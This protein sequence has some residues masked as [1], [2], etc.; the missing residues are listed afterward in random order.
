MNLINQQSKT[1]EAANRPT[2]LKR[3]QS[4]VVLALSLFLPGVTFSQ[5]YVEGVNIGYEH[6]P[7]K[8]KLPSGDQKFTGSNFKIGTSIPVF[9]TPNKSKYLIVGGN[10]EAF[11]FSGTHPDFE[12]KRVY[13]VSPTLGYSTM[14]S[15]KFNVT[16]LLMPTMNSD[17]KT[18][19]GSDI[20]MAAIVRGSWKVSEDLTWKAIIGYRQQFYGPQY[21]ALVGM[22]WKV[23]EK[24]QVY[25][26]LPHSLT[27]SY[28]VNEKVNTGFNLFVQNST[29]RLDN[30]D[31][32]FEYNT[33][34]P[35]LFLERYISSRW[36][37][38][39]TGAYTL[40]RNM[41]IYNKTD[42]AKGFIDFYELG[43]RQNPINPEVSSGLSFK[44]GLSYRIV[45]G[46]K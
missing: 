9:L 16:A 18:I 31:R 5:G 35:G 39:A 8:I 40:I 37:I 30:Q 2:F 22:D 41:E 1:N 3:Y 33:V 43:E 27:T 21:V 12:V 25:G 11:N 26:D 34:N 19:K 45:P 28:A 13:S 46:K 36:A 20:K 7:M 4:I 10:L 6:M 44:V 14:V 29:Y 32:Y 23:N 24:L 17:Y 15:K 38:R 42:K